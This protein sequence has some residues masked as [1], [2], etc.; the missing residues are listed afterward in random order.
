MQSR[1][2]EE[3][4]SRREKEIRE[5]RSFLGMLKISKGLTKK[6]KLQFL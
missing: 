6:T 4:I 3:R 1:K 5:I 2:K